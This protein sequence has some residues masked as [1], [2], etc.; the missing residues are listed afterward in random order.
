MQIQ[1]HGQIDRL[2]IPEDWL[3]AALSQE[4]LDTHS[5]RMFHP[6]NDA[7]VQLRL[8]YRGRPESEQ[9]GQ[10]FLEC[11]NLQPHPLSGSEIED[12]VAILREQ[13]QLEFDIMGAETM[14]LNGK[15]IL[16]VEGRWKDDPY[17]CGT[18]YIDADGT[19]RIV[20]EVTCFAPISSVDRQ[21]QMFKR[22]IE[23]IVWLHH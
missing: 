5:V 11:L 18:I 14:T 13:G 2:E 19:G 22:I 20:Q 21:R 8:I 6:S 7:K 1:N 12:L 23:S 10:R 9:D 16:W 17:W 4:P 15:I 3:E